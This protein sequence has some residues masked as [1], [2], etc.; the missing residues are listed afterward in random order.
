MKC[1]HP[2]AVVH[3][4][5][6]PPEVVHPREAVRLPGREVVLPVVAVQAVVGKNEE[7]SFNL[8]KL[9]V[10]LLQIASPKNNAFM[11]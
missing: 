4:A 7:I 1:L 8:P 5:V 9:I 3:P 6:H 2:L 10:N 11:N